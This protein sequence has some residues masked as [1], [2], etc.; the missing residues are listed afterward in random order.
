MPRATSGF[1][2][3]IDG[4]G[5]PGR[6]VLGL[7]SA[8]RPIAPLA[9]ILVTSLALALV[10]YRGFRTL[11]LYWMA[12]AVVCYASWPSLWSSPWTSAMAFL[13]RTA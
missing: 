11:L 9:G 2:D 13:Q 1:G 12:A 5:G 7:A 4:R 6:G 3:E 8:T 10:K